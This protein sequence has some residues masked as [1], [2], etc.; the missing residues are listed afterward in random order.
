[1][2]LPRGDDDAEGLQHVSCTQSLLRVQHQQLS[3]QAHCVLRHA[4]VPE[5]GGGRGRDRKRQVL[6]AEHDLKSQA[7]ETTAEGPCLQTGGGRVY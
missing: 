4:T 5:G 3:D 2:Q 1:M 6:F 7:Y